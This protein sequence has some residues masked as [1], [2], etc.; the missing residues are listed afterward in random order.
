MRANLIIAV[1]FTATMLLSAC[2]SSQVHVRDNN[3]RF[4]LVVV[5]NEPG[6]I[7]GL[8]NSCTCLEIVRLDVLNVEPVLQDF[9]FFASKPNPSGIT[10][11]LVLKITAETDYTK[12]KDILLSRKDVIAFSRH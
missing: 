2:K 11:R 10:M 9:L 3:D 7:E 8:L 4:L 1:L 6:V 5:K 12:I